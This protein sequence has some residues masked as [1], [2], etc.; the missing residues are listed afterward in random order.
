MD[1]Q[2]RC[3]RRKGLIQLGYGNYTGTSTLYGF[4]F[5]IGY[6]IVTLVTWWGVSRFF[7][8]EINP[9]RDGQTN[10]LTDAQT[11]CSNTLEGVGS[12][13]QNTEWLE[14]SA[15]WR[16]DTP[17]LRRSSA[18]DTTDNQHYRTECGERMLRIENPATESSRTNIGMDFSLKLPIFLKS[19]S[20]WYI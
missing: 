2:V 10:E 19:C 13:L 9:L 15:L 18:T 3:A 1:V 16:T 5:V 7:S 8:K 17:K 14:Y 12:W 6:Y 4:L 11:I 20:V